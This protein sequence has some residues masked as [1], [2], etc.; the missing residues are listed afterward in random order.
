MKEGK[1]H[2]TGSQLT[3]VRVFMRLCRPEKAS[4]QPWV[5]GRRPPSMRN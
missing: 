2:C 3:G 1:A 5:K 4:G